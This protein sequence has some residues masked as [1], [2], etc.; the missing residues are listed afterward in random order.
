MKNPVFLHHD[1]I[2]FA[3]LLSFAILYSKGDVGDKVEAMMWQLDDSNEKKVLITHLKQIITNMLTISAVIIP[4]VT[5][6]VR[7]RE[8]Y[9]KQARNI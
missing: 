2:T 1:G 8:A 9:N 5:M 7:Y 3:D 4:S 6:G